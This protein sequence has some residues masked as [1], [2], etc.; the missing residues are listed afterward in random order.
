MGH[1]R[2]LPAGHPWRYHRQFKEDWGGEDSLPP[3]E[4]SGEY[5]LH[6]FDTVPKAKPGK[7]SKQQG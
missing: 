6:Q 1:R 7:K 5:I 3:V 4:K 2:Y